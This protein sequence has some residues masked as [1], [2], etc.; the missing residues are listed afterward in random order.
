MENQ[1]QPAAQN[2]PAVV[3]HQG[4]Q[5][6]I[7]MLEKATGPDRELDRFIEETLP[8]VLRHPYRWSVQ[9][10]YVISGPDHPTYSAGQGYLPPHYTASTDDARQLILDGHEFGLG[11]AHLAGFY[12]AVVI[13][14]HGEWRG[15]GK[16]P[17]IALCIAAIKARA[18]A[19]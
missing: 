19:S 1:T 16:N 9:C 15:K 3:K 4:P 13:S 17:A 2:E 8:G 5:D 7:A 10:G 12:W 11:S 6:L 18:V 14:V